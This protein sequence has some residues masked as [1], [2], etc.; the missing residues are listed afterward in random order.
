MGIITAF[1]LSWSTGYLV[2]AVLIV[3]MTLPFVLRSRDDRLTA[4]QRPPAQALSGWIS[5]FRDADFSWAW[6]TRFLVQLGNGFGISY[7]LYFLQ[8]QV[9]YAKPEDGMNTLIELYAV[10]L[11]VAAIISGKL[12][13]RAGKRKRYVIA[14]GVVMSGGA[15]ILAVL[16]SFPAAMVAAVLMGAGFGIYLAVDVAL[17]TEVLP[18]A[19]ARAKDLGVIN[20]ANSAP[21]VLALAVG[22]PILSGHGGYPLLYALTAICALLGGVLVRQIKS[23]A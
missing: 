7:L 12:S 14:S 13:D 9:H 19:A 1:G 6:G 8:D 10:A 3:P 17:V 22:G 20:I 4:G 5:A 23:V 16:S 18:D 21:Q 15:A 11:F 2:V